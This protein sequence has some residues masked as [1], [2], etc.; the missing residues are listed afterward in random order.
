MLIVTYYWE[1]SPNVYLNIPYLQ[2]RSNCIVRYT[3]PENQAFRTKELNDRL[4]L[5]LIEQR[6]YSGM[7]C[8]GAK[9]RLTKALEQ[10]VMATRDKSRAVVNPNTGKTYMFRLSFIT[11]TLYSTDRHVTGKEAHKQCLEPFLQW[12]RRQYKTKL[13]VWKAELQKRGQIHYHITSDAYI[14]KEILQAKWNE[15]QRRAGYLD[16]FYRKFGRYNAPSTEIKKVRK[17]SRLA[18]YLVKEFTKTIQ[19]GKSL[20]GKTWD[21]SLNLKH[22]N[23]F[24]EM[25]SGYYISNLNRAIDQNRVEVVA[26]DTCILYKMK[27]EPSVNLLTDL[28]GERYRHWLKDICFKEHVRI[29]KVKQISQPPEILPPKKVNI[30]VIPDLFSTS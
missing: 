23:Y 8:P 29:Q 20:G 21:C 6:T 30:F 14:P 10:L 11:L 5:S 22:S 16:S 26:T 3:L 1:T 12:M 17:E 28:G 4:S 24:T 18:G 9:K 13:Y 25:E 15:L 2:F 19:N 27:N 7:L